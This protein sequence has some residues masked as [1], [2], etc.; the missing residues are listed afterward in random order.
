[1]VSYYEAQNSNSSYLHELPTQQ[2][3]TSIEVT[4]DKASIYYCD[5]EIAPAIVIASVD[6]HHLMTYTKEPE[7]S[8]QLRYDQFEQKLQTGDIVLF[9]GSQFTSVFIKYATHSNY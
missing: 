6:K 7:D 9:G 1:M 5:I 2:H 3:S 4:E 8:K